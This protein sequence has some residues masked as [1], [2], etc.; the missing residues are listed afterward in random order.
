MG[1]ST[2]SGIGKLL[3]LVLRLLVNRTYLPHDIN[4]TVSLVSHINVGNTINNMGGTSK[5]SLG[6][7][8]S[9]RGSVRQ[10]GR[11]PRAPWP[12][13]AGS[14]R[15]PGSTRGASGSLPQGTRFHLLSAAGSP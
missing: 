10:G 4:E 9:Q 14:T 5:P 12:C 1:R 15:C 13:G 7:A 2:V 11:L 8:S 6:T 3:D